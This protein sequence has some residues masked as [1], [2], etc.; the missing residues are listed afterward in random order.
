M[1][2]TE[3]DTEAEFES[4][5]QFFE[6]VRDEGVVLGD[7][8]YFAEGSGSATSYKAR[9]DE[10][11]V[12]DVKKADVEAAWEEHHGGEDA[13]EQEEEAESE[14]VHLGTFYFSKANWDTEQDRETLEEMLEEDGWYID[15]EV[16]SGGYRIKTEREG[17]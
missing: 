2:E 12:E 1:S 7:L 14:E 16:D 6:A 17:Q 8:E 5:E 4:K 11:E 9:T 15:G 13:E 10:G 3:S